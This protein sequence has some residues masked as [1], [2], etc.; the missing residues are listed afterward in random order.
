VSSVI[1][2]HRIIVLDEGH[3]VG[4]GTHHELLQ[5]CATYQEIVASQQTAEALS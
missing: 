2:A 1:S 4:M 3:I 5:T